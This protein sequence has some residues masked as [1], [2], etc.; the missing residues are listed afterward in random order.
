MI[1]F[2]A[3]FY[4]YANAFW[5]MPVAAAAALPMLLIAGGGRTTTAQVS[6]VDL[7]Q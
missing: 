6:S 7:V 5:L 4:G 1:G 2:T 3:A